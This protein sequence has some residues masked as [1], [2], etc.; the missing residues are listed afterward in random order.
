MPV[1]VPSLVAFLASKDSY[2]SEHQLKFY[3][4]N[5]AVMQD[6]QKQKEN[7]NDNENILLFMQDRP[8]QNHLNHQHSF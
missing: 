3:K 1:F 7:K 5:P 4:T 8:Q 2:F 6:F